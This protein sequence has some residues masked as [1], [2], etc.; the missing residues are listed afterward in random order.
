MEPK[1]MYHVEYVQDGDTD[2][3]QETVLL[4]DGEYKLLEARLTRAEE[5]GNL[6]GWKLYQ[7]DELCSY[8]DLLETLEQNRVPE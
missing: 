8:A 7:L 3:F 6:L 4:T 2:T 5:L 1:K